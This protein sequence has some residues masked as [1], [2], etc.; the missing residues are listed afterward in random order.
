MCL[1]K[2]YKPS[3]DRIGSNW[4]FLMCLIS[5]RPYDGT[6]LWY[7][8]V[9]YSPRGTY[10][11]FNLQGRFGLRANVVF[12]TYYYSVQKPLLQN[13]IL[14]CSN[15]NFNWW[16]NSCF[17]LPLWFVLPLSILSFQ[18]LNH[19]FL[20]FFQFSV[21]VD[22]FIDKTA[23]TGDFELVCEVPFSQVEEMRKSKEK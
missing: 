17:K 1:G 22:Y 16:I 2:L 18:I 6:P 20:L 4:T 8:T 5:K 10:C 14:Y 23:S 11:I 13:F 12:G 21:S 3:W 15:L 19:N 9:T 7:P